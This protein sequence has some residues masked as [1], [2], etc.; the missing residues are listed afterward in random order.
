[1]IIGGVYW[2]CPQVNSIILAFIFI[3][4]QIF[5]NYVTLGGKEPQLRLVPVKNIFEINRIQNNENNGL[6]SDFLSHRTRSKK[7]RDKC[8]EYLML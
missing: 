6:S 4:Q 7:R 3:L 2:H 5:I 8:D 1:M